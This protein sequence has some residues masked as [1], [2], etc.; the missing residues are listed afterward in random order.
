VVA[1]GKDE[2]L[3]QWSGNLLLLRVDSTAGFAT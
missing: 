1:L 3:R 2:F